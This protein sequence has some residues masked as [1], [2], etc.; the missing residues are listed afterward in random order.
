MY[1]EAHT[2]VAVMTGG[3]SGIGFAAAQLFREEGARVV[4]M[5]RGEE[6]LR[7]ALSTLGNDAHRVRGGVTKPGDRSRLFAETKARCGPV[8]V[9]FARLNAAVVKLAAITFADRRGNL[10]QR[11]LSLVPTQHPRSGRSADF[12]AGCEYSCT[13]VQCF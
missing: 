10:S 13:L 5:A 4:I 3:T 2:K 8:D 9:L 12:L 6:A 1:E 11:L 7:Q